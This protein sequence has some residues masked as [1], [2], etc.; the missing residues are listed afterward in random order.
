MTRA[1]VCALA[2]G[3]IAAV[4]AC[5]GGEVTGAGAGDA[6]RG[7]E[8]PTATPTVTCSAA[9]LSR[10]DP[11]WRSRSVVSGGL[12]LYANA[13]DVRTADRW[14]RSALWTKVP[15]IVD[16]HSPA[17]LAVAPR[18]AHR[19]GLTYGPDAL[20]PGTSDD[21]ARGL[22]RAPR[23]MRFV[24]CPDR[25]PVAWAGGLALA[26]RRLPVRF[27]VRVDGGPWR[28]LTLRRAG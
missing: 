12:G 17:T 22:A 10:V 3:A 28:R 27:R 9:V 4:S 14:G 21:G 23:S 6:E 18:D 20:S 1:T 8:R 2:A 25:S 24:P 7:S 16:E 15:V 26:D 11:G 13:T 19:V 5:D